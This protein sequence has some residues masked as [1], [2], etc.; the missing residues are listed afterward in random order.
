[1]ALNIPQS[2]WHQWRMPLLRLVVVL[3]R[4]LW[5]LLYTAFKLSLPMLLIWLWLSL[6][7]LPS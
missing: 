4:M 3:R 2:R 6:D 1:M 5:Q 7:H